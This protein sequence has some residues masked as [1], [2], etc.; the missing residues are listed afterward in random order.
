LR[1][2]LTRSLSTTRGLFKDRKCINPIYSP[3]IP[4]KNNCTAAK[5]NIVM[6]KDAIP[7]GKKLGLIS[8]ATK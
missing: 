3:I 7:I 2:K 5:K 4:I 6:C 8:F 1:S